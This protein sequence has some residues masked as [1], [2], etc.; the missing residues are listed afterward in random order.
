MMAGRHGDRNMRW[1]E[2]LCLQSGSTKMN[3]GI[4]AKHPAQCRM[5]LP[6]SVKPLWKCPH[7]HNQQS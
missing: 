5:G 3:A 2:T 6:S 4:Q 7:R 1:L